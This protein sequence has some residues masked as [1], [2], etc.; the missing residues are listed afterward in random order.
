MGSWHREGKWPY[1]DRCPECIT[2]GK[3]Q[4]RKC[5]VCEKQKPLLKENFAHA[6]DSKCIPCLERERQELEERIS[7][8]SLLC[9]I[10]HGKSKNDEEMVCVWDE[11]RAHAMKVCKACGEKRLDDA[12]DQIVF[13]EEQELDSR[14]SDG[15]ECI[16]KAVRIRENTNGCIAY[17]LEGTMTEIL[18]AA[19]VEGEALFRKKAPTREALYGDYDIIFHMRFAGAP[20]N[21]FLERTS[22][23]TVCLRP[24]LERNADDENENLETFTISGT[25]D[26]TTRD[27][28][29]DDGRFREC[30]S[31]VAR[32]CESNAESEDDASN[33][34]SESET[35]SVHW[36]ADLTGTTEQMYAAD[37]DPEDEE[38]EPTGSLLVLDQ[39]IQVPW[40]V[41]ENEEFEHRLIQEEADIF[42]GKPDYS[43]SWLCH[44]HASLPPLAENVAEHIYEFA[45]WRPK[46]VFSLEPGDLLIKMDYGR[47]EEE[48]Q[49]VARKT[50]K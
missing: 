47:N 11:E 38:E 25:I 45:T 17:N 9:A 48:M 24:K 8:K 27:K 2:A 43:E 16:R 4:H 34:N 20:L 6:Q 12:E 41:M 7:N 14:L 26:S 50:K 40:L 28:D 10:C 35:H 23:G 15:A 1:Q 5:R 49:V 19:P 29:V 39:A 31:L 32:S 46:P 18:R 30:F 36:R 13:R 42:L 37:S 3:L 33:T 21:F 22:R 44:G